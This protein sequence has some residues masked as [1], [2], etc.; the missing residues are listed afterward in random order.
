[1]FVCLFVWLFG[2]L[3]SSS[4]TRLYRGRAPGQSVWQFYVLPHMRQSWETMPSVSAGHI[5]LTPT[6]SW[7]STKIARMAVH[8]MPDKKNC[9]ALFSSYQNRLSLVKLRGGGGGGGETFVWLNKNKF[10]A[11]KKKR[12]KPTNKHDGFKIIMGPRTV[13]L[14][15]QIFPRRC[16]AID[17]YM[18][19][20]WK[21]GYNVTVK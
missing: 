13:L 16:E 7:N 18:T 6:Q 2:F 14:I 8:D 15:I 3:T 20:L 1:M 5:I 12:N 17:V 21:Q 11:K 9:D 19:L 10:K 4:T